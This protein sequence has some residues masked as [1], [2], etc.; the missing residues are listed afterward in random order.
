MS[1]KMDKHTGSLKSII[2]DLLFLI[3]YIGFYSQGSK[4]FTLVLVSRKLI[5]FVLYFRIK[6]IFQPARCVQLRCPY[7]ISYKQENFISYRPPQLH[8]LL[9]KVIPIPEWLNYQKLKK[10]LDS[11]SWEAKNKILR[12]ISLELS[13]V[14]QLIDMEA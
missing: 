3:F 1:D 4:F 11:T 12:S 10:V 14:V 5:S 9:V 2:K 13:L 8:L 7:L 6:V